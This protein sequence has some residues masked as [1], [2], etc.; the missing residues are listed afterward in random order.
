[1]NSRSLIITILLLSLSATGWSQEKKPQVTRSTVEREIRK[2]ARKTPV[3][4]AEEQLDKELRELLQRIPDSLRT[5]RLLPGTVIIDGR[6]YEPI[7]LKHPQASIWYMPQQQLSNPEENNIIRRLATGWFTISNGQAVNWQA[8][9][10]VWGL[11]SIYPGS[12]LDA[13]TLSM[14]LPRR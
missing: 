14:P 3:E 7:P 5:D 2:E 1:M 10:S 12:Y 8:G 9:R 4:R 11:G 13:R 6:V